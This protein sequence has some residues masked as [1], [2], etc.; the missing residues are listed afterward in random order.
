VLAPVID[1]RNKDAV[2]GLGEH[3][4]ELRRRLI[5]ALL[6]IAPI[7]IVSLYFG[8]EILS[9]LLAPVKTALHDA[10][11]AALFQATGVLETFGAYFK[12]SAVLTLILG[13]PWAIFQLWKFVAPGLYTHEKRFAYL[14]AP[15]SIV[16][17]IGGAA[18]AYYVMLPVMLTFLILF[19]A[20]VGQERVATAPV[21]PG[22]TLPTVAVLSAD[23]ASP[24]PGQWWINTSRN[25][26]R[27]AVGP[28]AIAAPETAPTTPAS[29]PP[30]T[31]PPA[32]P[33]ASAATPAPA[34]PTPSTAA[35]PAPT[36]TA[37]QVF[38]VRLTSS[39]LIDQVPR[40][41]ETVDLLLMMGLAFAAAFQTPVVVLLLGWAGIIKPPMLRKYRRHVVA[42]CALLSAVLT[43][44][45]DPFSMLLLM[46]PMYGLYELGLLLLVLLPASRVAGDRPT[47]NGDDDPQAPASEPPGGP[48]TGP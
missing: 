39:A 22:L 20:S 15:M 2:M 5:F 28:V 19:G 42:A 48:A 18:F 36:A 25:E 34:S 27:V 35:T 6:G 33:G 9:F 32:D 14:L 17:S 31:P 43:P 24:T 23:P 3:L 8:K 41:Q 26:L 13:G 30:P 11:Q 47:R 37:T 21:P 10:G 45:P 40:V 46:G 38:G 16:L 7:F 1:R 12:V 29:A 4:D 44:S